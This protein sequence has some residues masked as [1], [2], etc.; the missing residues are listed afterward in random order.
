MLLLF[1]ITARFTAFYEL[2]VHT[3]DLIFIRLMGRLGL[4]INATLTKFGTL[5]V[6]VVLDVI[7]RER[8]LIIKAAPCA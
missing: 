1:P 3:Q 6:S 7:Q 2:T 8:S 5:D 4:P